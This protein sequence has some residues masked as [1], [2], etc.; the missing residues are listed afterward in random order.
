MNIDSFTGTGSTPSRRRFWDKVTQAV[1]ASQKIAGK[2]VS[3]DEHQG[4]GSIISVNPQ[5]QG[6]TNPTGACCYDDGTC[7][8]LTESDC[9]DAGGNWQGSDTPCSEGLCV[10]VC[11][12]CSGCVD[13]ST[14]DSCASDGGT[15]GDFQTT[16][17]DDPA[18][19]PDASGACCSDDGHGGCTITTEADCVGTYQ[20]DCSVCDPDPCLNCGTHS[21]GLCK[22]GYSDVNKFCTGTGGA[23]R[24]LTQVAHYHTTCRCCG[25]DGKCASC[26]IVSTW[27]IDP[28]TCAESVSS[29]RSSTCASCNFDTKLVQSPSPC[30]ISPLSCLTIDSPTTAHCHSDQGIH[31]CDNTVEFVEDTDVVLSDEYTTAMLISNAETLFTSTYGAC[32]DGCEFHSELD[33]DESCVTITCVP[34]GMSPVFDDPFFRNN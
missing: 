29:V 33:G 20:G 1:I 14:P 27:T 18:P 3:V 13:D 26:D 15:F 17:A 8:D 21:V 25:G 12:E 16:C 34:A 5:R 23:S 2:N 22:C 10:G 11:C 28:T 19:C 31:G 32:P 6:S 24:Y 7:D 30:H 4:Y 9:N